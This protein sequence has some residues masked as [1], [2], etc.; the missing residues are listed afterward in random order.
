MKFILLL[1]QI[2][3]LVMV[4]TKCFTVALTCDKLIIRSHVFGN[5]GLKAHKEVME[6]GRYEV[7]TIGRATSAEVRSLI[8][9]LTGASDVRYTVAWPWFTAILQPKDLKKV[10]THY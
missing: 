4:T 3:F 10:I 2:V 1:L 7:R 9:G 5:I 6:A 8:A